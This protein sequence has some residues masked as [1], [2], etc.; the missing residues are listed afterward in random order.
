MLSVV[1]PAHNEEG[2]LDAS[3]RDVAEALRARGHQFEIVI[4]ENGS[5]DATAE[6]SRRLAAEVPEVRALS[7]PDPDYGRAL[8]TGF[9]DA[10]GDLVVIFD[11]DYYEFDFLDRAMAAVEGPDGP[12]IVIGSKRG[13][14]SVDTRAWQRRLITTVF[15]SILRFG[16]GLKV[17]DTHGIKVVRRAPLKDVAAACRYGTDLFDTE[18]VLRAERAGLKVTEIPVLVEER[19]PSRSGI[20]RRIPRTVYGLTRLRLALWRESR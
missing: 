1:M 2:L 19:R 6:I 13:E 8:R 18:L 11:V 10:A 3:V 14:G 16:F 7:L 9:L 15:S 17:S 20:A 4:V 5:T 12:D